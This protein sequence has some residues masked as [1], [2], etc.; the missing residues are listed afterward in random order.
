MEKK[1]KVIH[2]SLNIKQQWLIGFD[3]LGWKCSRTK[4]E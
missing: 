1:R 3:D 2:C 4:K